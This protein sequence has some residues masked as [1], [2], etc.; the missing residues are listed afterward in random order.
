MC[1][2]TPSFVSIVATNPYT[3]THEASPDT[4]HTCGSRK[5]PFSTG[6]CVYGVCVLCCAAAGILCMLRLFT[7]HGEYSHAEYF[8]QKYLLDTTTLHNGIRHED[9]AAIIC[10][11]Y[12]VENVRQ[13]RSFWRIFFSYLPIFSPYCPTVERVASSVQ[14]IVVCLCPIRVCWAAM[15]TSICVVL[16][17]SRLDRW[18]SGV[19]KGFNIGSKWPISMVSQ[20]FSLLRSSNGNGKNYSKNES[21]ILPLYITQIWKISLGV[22]C[23]VSNRKHEK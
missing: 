11:E 1:G 7:V 16:R 15:F 9:S 23:W 19:E 21:M 14:S 20:T 2:R 6:A 17:F 18:S 13:R 8:G 4:K 10:V 5:W 22:G 12:A 3:Y